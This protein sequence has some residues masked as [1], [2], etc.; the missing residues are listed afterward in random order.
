MVRT[1]PYS[2][3]TKET[4]S[5]MENQILLNASRPAHNSDFTY[6][7]RALLHL[8]NVHTS[9]R[10]F[11]L[12]ASLSFEYGEQHIRISQPQP[13]LIKLYTKQ[14]LSKKPTL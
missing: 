6:S 2:K 10:L 9:E 11:S 14:P 1:V 12:R 3:K 5:L 4:Q 8:L 13:P 7:N